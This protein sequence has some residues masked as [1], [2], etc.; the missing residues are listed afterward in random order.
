MNSMSL[1][2]ASLQQQEICCSREFQIWISETRRA[3]KFLAA[4]NSGKRKFSAAGKSAAAGAA[5]NCRKPRLK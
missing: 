3:E 1:L 5:G 2:Q 4:P